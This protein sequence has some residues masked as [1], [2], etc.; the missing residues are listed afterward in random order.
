MPMRTSQKGQEYIDELFNS[1]HNR[2]I[3][4]VLRISL[5]SFNELQD[6]CLKHTAL[7]STRI[8]IQLKL[9]VFLFIVSR[10]ASIRNA[11]E[12]FMLSTQTISK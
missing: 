8:S 5:S 6:W 1:S 3:Y 11:A 2:R 10:P 7:K 4:D 9:V 12:R